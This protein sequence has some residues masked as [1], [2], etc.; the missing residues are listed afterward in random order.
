ML[1]MTPPERLTDR[2]PP[3]RGRLTMSAPLAQSTWFQ[4]GGPADVLFK[5]ADRDDLAAFL[6]GLPGDIQVTVL[7]VASN[8]IIRDGGVRGV[9]IRLGR[10]FAGIR[11]DGTRVFAGAAALDASIAKASAAAGLAGLEFLVG[12]PGTLGG[13]M[14]TNAGAYGTELKDVLVSATVMD[15]R[16][17]VQSVPGDALGFGY[18]HSTAPADWIL[19]EAELKA[20]PGNREA[21]LARMAEISAKRAATQPIRER[22]GGSTFAN[23]AGTSAWKVID[24]AGCRGLRHG[25]AMVSE[26]HCNFLINTGD[27]TADD[28]ETLGETVR[29]RVRAHSG[30]DL[31][32]EIRRIGEKAA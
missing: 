2:M 20:E 12:V 28:L 5:P 18:R 29:D 25:G 6:A 4:V 23:P 11:V 7:G 32:W 22:T 19:L 9:V 27:A 13:G 3:V 15:R 10:A 26:Q 14:R 24:A 21:G 30:I 17:R 8:L 31:R 16:G 1:A